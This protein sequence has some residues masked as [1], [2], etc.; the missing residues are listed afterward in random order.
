MEAATIV[1][2]QIVY[3]PDAGFSGTDTLTYEVKD[4]NGNLATATVTVTVNDVNKPPVAVD[5]SA[6]TACSVVT[7]SVLDNDSDPDGDTLS[8]IGV[9]DASLGTA[10][11]SGNNIVYTPS[12]TCGKGNTGT[13]TFSY[14][15]SDGNGNTASANVTVDVNGVKGDGS[16]NA[17]PDDVTTHEGK[18]VTINVLANDAGTGL[19]IIAVDNPK[20]GTAEI[21]GDTSCLYTRCRI[22]WHG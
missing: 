6:S 16:T 8:I 22:Y 9:G 12:N 18:P 19:K 11:I 15:I 17:E 14:T 13:D 20:N 21:V 3:T 7:I 5:D 2:G 1:N 4:P 10:V